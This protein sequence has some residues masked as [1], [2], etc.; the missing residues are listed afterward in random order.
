M[1]KKFDITEHNLVPK[2][3]KISEKEVDELMSKF[4]I[5]LNQLPKISIKDPAV[6]QLSLKIGDV[7]KVTRK[8]ATAGESACYRC[9]IDA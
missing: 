6:R 7:I 9:V 4:S 8:S 3:D 1:T 5:M 2:H